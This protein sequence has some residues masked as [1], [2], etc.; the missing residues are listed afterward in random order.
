MRKMSLVLSG[1][2]VLSAGCSHPGTY[3]Q[4]RALD[5]VDCFDVEVGIGGVV[6]LEVNATDWFGTGIGLSDT[7]KWGFA[8][9]HWISR[10][11]GNNADMHMGFPVTMA[12]A[13]DQVPPAEG[14]CVGPLAQ[15]LV[16]DGESR[17]DE[18]WSFQPDPQRPVRE[19]GRRS[20][21]YRSRESV[22]GVNLPDRMRGETGRDAPAKL[23][24]A[25]QVDVSA[26]VMPLSA[27]VGFSFGQFADL[28]L[29]F[30]GFDVAGD[31]VE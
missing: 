17:H 30:V 18:S 22:L 4:N 11:N 5:F 31:D 2:A 8:G 16:L 25:F 15:F 20:P 1:L 7:E 29:G 28:I 12:L 9:R 10:A 3:W 21:L 24:D 23:A 6:D 19:A 26:T 14:C 27:R 13:E